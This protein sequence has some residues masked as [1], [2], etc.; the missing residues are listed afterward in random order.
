[1]WRASIG[2]RAC[3]GLASVQGGRR[4]GTGR[5]KRPTN[6]RAQARPGSI[7]GAGTRRTWLLPSLW[8]GGTLT[9]RLWD[10]RSRSPFPLRLKSRACRSA[11]RLLHTAWLAESPQQRR[12][13][14]ARACLRGTG[15]LR[16]RAPQPARC[17][18]LAPGSP[19]RASVRGETHHWLPAL[20]RE[21]QRAEGSPAP[22]PGLR[23]GST[24]APSF[25]P[26]FVPDAA[27][28]TTRSTA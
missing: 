9:I 13:P 6:V 18:G 22:A 16:R 23:R 8:G 5:R 3:Q 14:P 15:S 1:M 19:E 10:V 2:L 7:P 12:F 17:T 24:S 20:R 11:L 21:P 4:G 27:R 26:E 25:V 28:V